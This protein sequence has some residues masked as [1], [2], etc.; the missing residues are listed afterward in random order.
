M[1]IIN[2]IDEF[3][4][5]ILRSSVVIVLDLENYD[6]IINLNQNQSGS[7]TGENNKRVIT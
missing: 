3:N 6:L 1:V 2:K 7:F 5:V 4:K